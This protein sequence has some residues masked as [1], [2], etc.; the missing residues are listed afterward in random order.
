[1]KN[2]YCDNCGRCKNPNTGEQLRLKEVC[3]ANESG[4]AWYCDDCRANNKRKEVKKA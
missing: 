3:L 1:M 2:Y 4:R